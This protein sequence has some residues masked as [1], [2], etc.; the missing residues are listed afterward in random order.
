VRDQSKH[1]VDPEEIRL[2]AYIPDTATSRLDFAAYL[3]T[4]EYMDR[5][6]G[7]LLDEIRSGDQKKNTVV[8]FT[9][10]NGRCQVRGKG[11]LYEPGIHIPLI[12]WAP[13]L[14]ESGA[15]SAGSTD[16]RIISTLDITA[17]ILDL[18]GARMPEYLEGS[19]FIGRDDFQAREFIYAARDD[20]DEVEDCSRSVCDGKF[21]FIRN[22]RPD[23]PWD[24]HQAY[25]DFYRPVIHEMRRLMAQGQLD[26]A[27]RVFLSPT[28]PQLELYDWATDPDE[29]K[30][31][32]DDPGYSDLLWR[33]EGLMREY[34]NTHSDAGLLDYGTR[35]PSRPPATVLRDWV[36]DHRPDEWQKLVHDVFVKRDY[37]RKLYGSS[38][39][40]YSGD[41]SVP[42]ASERGADT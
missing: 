27:T 32:A 21:N 33:M 17:S 37:Y 5:E 42:Q 18:A 29:I 31:L 25:L 13:G 36:R 15:V 8:I 10:D 35:S 23:V 9:A 41:G 14:A 20:W 11:Y 24:A 38:A 39:G 12:V 2:P 30:N 3:D 28:K 26:A 7:M 16:A 6:V 34:Q 22:Y 1:P 4:V 19:S 40:Q